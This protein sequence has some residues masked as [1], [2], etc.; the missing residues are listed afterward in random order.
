MMQ[1]SELSPTPHGSASPRQALSEQDIESLVAAYLAVSEKLSYEQIQR[2]MNTSRATVAR[3][4]QH[5]KKNLFL[6][7]EP[8]VV[9]PSGAKELVDERIYDAKMQQDLR[10]MLQGYGLR[11][12]TIVPDTPL[13]TGDP[14]GVQRRVGF[15]A[16]QRLSSLFVDRE[17]VVG[18]NWGHAVQ[19]AV[20]ALTQADDD[21][22]SLVFFPMLGD[23][24]VD[25]GSREQY[26]EAMNCGA[27]TLARRAAEAFRAPT[28]WRLTAP[29]VISS[30]VATTPEK[31]DTIWEL[32]EQDVSYVRVFGRGYHHTR[33]GQPVQPDDSPPL[34]KRATAIV[35][36]TSSLHAD[37]TLASVARVLEPDEFDLLRKA[38]FAGDLGGHPVADPETKITDQRA[39]AIV[40]S[41]RNLLVSPLPDDFVRIAEEARRKDDEGAGVFLISTGKH[42]A[43]SL[44]A[45][46]RNRAV[47]EL[48]TDRATGER[49]LQILRRQ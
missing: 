41:L 5:A 40:E 17:G 38:G 43:H 34:I 22:P 18:V 7:E 23:F 8:K 29:A 35:T 6:V 3:R 48:F 30:A 36:G 28:P 15:A 10:L 1:D 12:V 39:L 45:L 47:N 32:V 49:M 33:S 31:L 11:R 44:L 16:A 13:A 24:S 25:E 9:F 27:N 46:V 4:L 20:E 26:A 37:S 2:L 14:Y 21:N 42:K 19:A